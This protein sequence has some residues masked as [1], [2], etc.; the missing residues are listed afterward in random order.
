MEEITAAFPPIKQLFSCANKHIFVQFLLLPYFLSHESK[1]RIAMKVLARKEKSCYNPFSQMV[2]ATR[3]FL[4]K[5]CNHVKT[6]PTHFFYFI[7]RF[8]WLC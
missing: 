7:N 4:T 2:K 6:K 1:P 5:D 3:I 8:G